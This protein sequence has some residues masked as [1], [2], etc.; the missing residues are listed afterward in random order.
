[1]T[2]DEFWALIAHIDRDRLRG[3]EAHDEAALRPLV[4]GLT[5]LERSGLQSFQDHLAQ[6]LYDIDGP[7]HADAAGIAGSSDDSFLYVRC[8]VVAMGR[9]VYQRTLHD[10]GQMPGQECESLLYAARS[11]WQAQTGEDVHFETEVSFESGSNPLWSQASPPT[12]LDYA[13]HLRRDA[14]E[15]RAM[16][17]KIDDPVTKKDMLQ[18]AVNYERMAEQLEKKISGG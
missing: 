6:A 13:A 10:P 18:I 14:Q 17:E 4:Q 12:E 8:F 7:A 16:A 3:G 2:T 1:M 5:A 9:D 11:A 15:T